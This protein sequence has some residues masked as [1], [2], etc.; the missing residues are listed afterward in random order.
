MAALGYCKPGLKISGGSARLLG[1]DIARMPRADVRALRGRKVAY[2]AQSSAATFNPA[3]TVGYQVIETAV[4]SG[5]MTRDAATRKAVEIFRELRLPDPETIGARYPHQLS[6]GQLQRLM[7][8]MAL[9]TGPELLVLDEPTTALDVTTQVEVLWAIRAAISRRNI[10][11]IYISHDLAVVAQMAHRVAVIHGGR[12]LE[13]GPVAGFIKGGR[14]EYTN[15]LIAAVSPVPGEAGAGPLEP[16]TTEPPELLTAEALSVSYE[17]RGRTATLALDGASL[18]LHRGRT[19]A[20][21]GESGSGKSTLAR[22][23]IGLT[24]PRSGR[25]RLSGDDLAGSHRARSLDAHRRVQ[26]VHQMADT[27]LNPRHKIAKVLGRPLA[28]YHGLGRR[29]R[30]ARTVELLDMVG[31]TP[32]FADR[33]PNALSGGQK[34]RVCLARALA[35]EPDV[36]ICDEVISALDSIVAAEILALLKEL[37]TRTGVSIVFITHDIVV[38]SR[39]S[40]RM[41]VM[42]KGRVV[43]SGPTEDV[44]APPHHPYT[45]SLLRAIPELRVG[46][47]EDV[48]REG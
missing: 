14:S 2:V 3:M 46:W 10:G 40:H 19:V 18:K 23:I 22:A 9:C 43:D 20:I 17:G 16:A 15:R 28:F 4:V 36:I 42:H 35:A 41:V 26:F 32:D 6:G 34:Q 8:A 29:A 7:L 39:I 37:Q 24:S 25:T 48:E 5:A 44:M 30:Q 27:A 21:I 11:A 33:F 31:L 45:Q 1:Q 47:L 13:E 38:A 12:V